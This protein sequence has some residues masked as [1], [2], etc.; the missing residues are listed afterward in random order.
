MAEV[1]L[2]QLFRQYHNKVYHLALSLSRNQKDAEDILQNTFLKV[3]KNLA[4]FRH[5]S[6][7]STWIYR[8]A[9]NEAL[10]VLR[11]RRSLSRLTNFLEYAAKK[12]PSGLYVNWPQVPSQQL[13]DKE[14][15]ERVDAAIKYIPL[16]YRAALL[17]HHS[18]GLSLKDSAS[19]MGLSLNGFKTRMHRAY[20]LI[21]SQI[22]DY[23]KDKLPKE[24]KPQKQCKLLMRFVYDYAKGLLEKEKKARFDE[25]IKECQGC[26]AFL[27]S[28]QNA[29]RI[30]NAL[31]CQDIPPEL[32]VKISTFLRT[33]R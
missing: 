14:F 17:L 19:V 33:Y 2:E 29:L 4:F 21:R 25:H 24:F 15:K 32:R 9:Y 22:A 5:Q 16:Q 28:Y 10:M 30:T 31:E 1:T 26:N 8:I 27:R 6:K 23:F 20:L 18:N 3:T 7:I 13:L 11:K 12:V